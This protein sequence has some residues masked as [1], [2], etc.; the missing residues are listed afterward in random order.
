M[1]NYFKDCHGCQDRT[2]GCHS[3]CERYERNYEKNQERLRRLAKQRNEMNII[4]GFETEQ[5]LKNKRRK[6][7]KV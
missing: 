2:L 7:I 4:V 5:I 3:T 6:G 1:P